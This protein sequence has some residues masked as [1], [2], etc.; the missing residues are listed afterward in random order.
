VTVH[1]ADYSAW[2]THYGVEGSD[3]E[4]SSASDGIPDLMKYAMGLDPTA[5]YSGGVLFKQVMTIGN[6]EYFTISFQ[7]RE[8]L[9]GVAVY[10]EATSDLSDGASWMTTPV[11]MGP[12]IENGDGTSTYTFRTLNPIDQTSRFLRISVEATP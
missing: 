11:D 10:V 9:T 5:H 12:T 1:P 6:Q 8:N 7:L 2:A 3:P 4:V